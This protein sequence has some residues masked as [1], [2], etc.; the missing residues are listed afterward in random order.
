MD[1]LTVAVRQV[2]QRAG[3]WRPGR[4]LHE[5]RRTATSRMLRS[6]IDPRTVQHILGHSTLML[7]ERYGSVGREQ[8]RAAG[9]VLGRVAVPLE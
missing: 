6:G 9:D 8:L 2:F 1:A 7:L 5:L 3:L 4:G